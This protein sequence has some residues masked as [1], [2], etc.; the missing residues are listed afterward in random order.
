MFTLDA[1]NVAWEDAG[2]FGISQKIL[3][4]DPDTGARTLLLRSPPR[5]GAAMGDR[6]PQHHPVDEEFLCLSGRFTLEGTD[7]LTPMMYVYYPAGLVHGFGV[8]VPD[9]YEVYLRNSGPLATERV[10]A[11]TMDRPYFLD[12]QYGGE[13]IVSDPSRLIRD[14][15][16]SAQ[17]SIITLRTDEL[18][19]EGALILCLPAG[20]HVDFRLTGSG[21]AAE[22]FVLTGVLRLGERQRLGQYGYAALDGPADLR[23]HGIEPTVMLLN[24]RDGELASELGRQAASSSH[25]VNRYLQA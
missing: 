8:D 24:H 20:R 21:A 5:P 13:V 25:A 18:A 7:W 1:E 3:K 9:G 4:Q 16:E 23:V 10:D 11:P 6:R 14:G 17:V 12:S 22:I 19:G 2:G 15:L